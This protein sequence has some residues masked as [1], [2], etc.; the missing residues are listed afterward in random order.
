MSFFSPAARSWRRALRLPANA[1]S[2]TP[3]KSLSVNLL[4]KN[5][6]F[7]PPARS[8]C[9]AQAW[10]GATRL[11]ANAYSLLHSLQDIVT[12]YPHPIFTSRWQNKLFF[13]QILGVGRQI[14]L[15]NNLFCIF[16]R[17][18][19]LIFDSPLYSLVSREFCAK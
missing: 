6:S 7:S 13:K 1:Y 15:K 3:Q 19:E 5:S 12:H 4:K 8:P 11:P 14:C 9:R 10:R 16:L 17:G 18:I 2:L